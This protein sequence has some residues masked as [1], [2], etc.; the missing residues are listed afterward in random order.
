L[1]G[2][3]G[4]LKDSHIIAIRNIFSKR[5]GLG[6]AVLIKTLPEQSPYNHA[7]MS[8]QNTEKYTLKGKEVSKQDYEAFLAELGESEFWRCAKQEV[9]GK[10]TSRATHKIT[11]KEY[12]IIDMTRFKTHKHEINLVPEGF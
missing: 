1:N 6:G 5:F 8:E 12:F 11:N 10:S 7:A 3:V 4:H 2:F 9:G